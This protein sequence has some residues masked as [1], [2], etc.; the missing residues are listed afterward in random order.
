MQ[1]ISSDVQQPS[2]Q[3]SKA[4]EQW[5]PVVLVPP[6][7]KPSIKSTVKLLLRGV[8]WLLFAIAVLTFWLGGRVISVFAKTD[9][10]LAELEGIGIAALFAGLGATAKFAEEHF[11]ED[12]KD[13]TLNL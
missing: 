8:A 7:M 13:E 4:A 9:R 12:K 1:P 10:I 2:N 11:Q 6:F 5:Y 3:A